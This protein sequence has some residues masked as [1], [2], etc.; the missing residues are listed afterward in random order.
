[1]VAE[2]EVIVHANDVCRIV[3]I[4]LAELVQ[5]P[6]FL[7]RLSMETLFI[8][9]HLQSDI[10]A[11]LVVEDMHHLSK[12]AFADHFEHLIAVGN[13]IMWNLTLQ[14]KSKQSVTKSINKSVNQ[15]ADH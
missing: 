14:V 2:G 7:L 9:N 6:D 12:T 5:D 10:D 1:V 15:S 3:L 13:V 4:D 11:V 8:A